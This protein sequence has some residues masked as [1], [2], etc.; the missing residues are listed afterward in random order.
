MI[1]YY[2]SEIKEM[3]LFRIPEI[4]VIDSIRGAKIWKN[5]IQ[6]YNIYESA[7]EI[8]VKK[9]IQIANLLNIIVQ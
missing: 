3:S 2:I 4:L 8:E 5:W 1:W 6:N 9:Q 7:I